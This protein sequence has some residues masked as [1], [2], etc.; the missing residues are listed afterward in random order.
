MLAQMLRFALG[1]RMKPLVFTPGEIAEPDAPDVPI[2]LYVHI[3]FC[4]TLCPFCP[5]FKEVYDEQTAHRLA[6]AL[7]QE[8]RMRFPG[9]PPVASSLY[10]GGGSPALMAEHLEGVINVARQT[11]RLDGPAGVELHPRDVAGDLPAR[12]RGMGVDM[13]SVGV[14]SFQP[15]CLEALGREPLDS[16]QRLLCL[17]KAGFS[18]M[19]VDLI[20][21]IPGQ[22]VA[23]LRLDMKQAVECGAT[24][25]S[26][27][28][29]I[30]F[31]FTSNCRQPMG[32]RQQRQMLT[33]LAETARDLGLQRTSVW[34]FAVPGS[35]RYSSVTRDFF[36][37]F[38]PSA[39]SLGRSVFSL[40]TF[41][42]AEYIRAVSAGQRPVALSLH[43]RGRLRALYWLFWS[44]Y[45]LQIDRERFK[46]AFGQ[47]IERSLGRQ[48][49]WGCLLGLVARG[50]P[51]YQ[52]TV[53]GAAAYHLVEQAYTHA[54][55]DRVWGAAGR[56]PWPQRLTVW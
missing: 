38:G 17:R 39:A 45:T 55:I 24:Q 46:A 25:V 35:L 5:Y 52:L 15:G 8:I 53:R 30:D 6:G 44:C 20:F 27:Y 16:Q 7:T 1:G 28:P 29:F 34:T 9:R 41:S 54:Y 37:G 49:A 26:T 51:G 13:V 36:E 32:R 18:A 43:M 40:N 42:V 22:T 48:L 50:G 56:T 33:S 47:E 10:F 21:G 12:L 31:T 3:P 11:C 19:D 4:R 23:D 2:G 14:Q